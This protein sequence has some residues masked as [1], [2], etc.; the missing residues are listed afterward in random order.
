MTRLYGLPALL[1]TA[2]CFAAS[3]VKAQDKSSDNKSVIIQISNGLLNGSKDRLQGSGNVIEQARNLTGFKAVRLDGPIDIKLHASSTE[4][5]T[6]RA[7]DNIVPL[8]HTVVEG[9]VL[10]VSINKNTGFRTRNAIQVM[11]GFKQLQ[12]AAIKGSGDMLIEG[13]QAAQFDASIS[14]SGD[15]Q[16][17][18]ASIGDLTVSVA[19]SGDLAISGNAPKQNISVAGSGNVSA[20]KLAGKQVKVSVAGSGDVNVKASDTLEATIAG[21]GNIQYIGTPKLSRSIAG[22][23]EVAQVK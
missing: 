1:C 14:G 18:Q 17:D 7:D 22:S 10:V 5:V 12:A 13:L 3:G 21:S 9:E 8:V 11:A 23:G 2:L 4:T 15:M 19:G 20:K 16:I 6:V